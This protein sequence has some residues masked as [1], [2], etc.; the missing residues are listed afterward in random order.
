MHT[1]ESGSKKER[2]ET[3]CRGERGTKAERGGDDTHV[4]VVS[5]SSMP[6]GLVPFG[7]CLDQQQKPHAQTHNHRSPPTNSSI[8]K[9]KPITHSGLGEPCLTNTHFPGDSLSVLM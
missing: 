6:R 5:R 2:H 9:H 1:H 7:A 8:Q 4:A 3:I